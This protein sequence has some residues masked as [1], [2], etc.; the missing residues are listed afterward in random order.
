V[1]QPV[2]FPFVNATHNSDFQIVRHAI[3]IDEHRAFFRQ[4]LFGTPK[5]PTAQDIQEVWFAGVHSDVGGSYPESESQLSK[6]PLR[7]IVCEAELAGL[8]VDDG[9]KADILGG[10]PPYVAPDPLTKN[11]HES[12]SRWWWIAEFWPKLVHV[13][14]SPGVWKKRLKLNLARRRWIADGSVFHRSVDQR[15]AATELNYRPTNLPK[16]HQTAS[17]HC[18]SRSGSLLDV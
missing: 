7:W 1:Y 10:K 11:Q 5:D 13:E 3:S 9:R 2:K 15:L 4:N 14:T 17:D 12:L 8:I 18:V 6:I 16:S